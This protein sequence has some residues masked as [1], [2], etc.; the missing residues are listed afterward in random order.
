MISDGADS[1][2]LATSESVQTPTPA[3]IS[4]Q[5]PE[6]PVHTLFTGPET[7]PPD[8][9]IL[10]VRHDDFWHPMRNAVSIEV[11]VR[12][13]GYV[14]HGFPRHP[15]A[16]M[17]SSWGLEALRLSPTKTPHRFEFEVVPDQTGKSF[18]HFEVGQAPN[19]PITVNNRYQFT[20]RIIRDKIRV[21]RVVG[22][23][24]WDER[25]LRKLLQKESQRRPH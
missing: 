18:L 14:G 22:R 20:I 15:C 19:E 11:D 3:V 25:Y 21:L 16:R 7:A 4:D 1:S 12:V 13:N 24:S 17:T 23:P 5:A 9:A 6:V 8:I 2:H 10:N